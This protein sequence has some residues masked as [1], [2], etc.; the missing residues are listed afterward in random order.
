MSALRRRTPA[1]WPA[2]AASPSLG[3]TDGVLSCLCDMQKWETQQRF[4]W[5]EP[6]WWAR[7]GLNL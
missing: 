5:S 1:T 3:C 4:R 2:S 7:Q 6:V